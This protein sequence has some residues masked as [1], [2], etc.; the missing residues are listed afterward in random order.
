MKPLQMLRGQTKAA[1]KKA[2]ENTQDALKKSL[3]KQMRENI[4]KMNSLGTEFDIY[5]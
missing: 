5:T 1:T 2:H 3:C 4:G